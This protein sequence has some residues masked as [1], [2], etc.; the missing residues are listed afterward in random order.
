MS[1]RINEAEAAKAIVRSF[2]EGG[3]RGRITDFA[4]QLA[5]EFQL[6]VPDYLPWGGHF[7][8][9][10]Y[11]AR[12]PEIARAL[13]FTKL[14]YLSFIGERNHVVA[15]IAIGVQGTD[16]TTIISEHWDIANNKVVGLRV[17][18]F[19]PKALLEQFAANRTA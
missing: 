18:Y 7:D 6:Y 17:A 8:K 12:L 13:D 9:A 5:E 1:I 14:S 16:E 3:A 19:D 2:Y 10:G 4:S 11:I 15:L